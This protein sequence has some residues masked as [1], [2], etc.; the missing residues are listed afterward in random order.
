MK[1]SFTKTYCLG[2]MQVVSIQGRWGHAACSDA[3]DNKENEKKKCFILLQLGTLQRQTVCLDG[4]KTRVEQILT[5]PALQQ[6][7]CF[8]QMITTGTSIIMLK[9]LWKDNDCAQLLRLFS[10]I[11]FLLLLILDVLL[12]SNYYYTV[13]TEGN[14]TPK[15]VF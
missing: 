13:F 1:Q 4:K 15:P 5:Q 2:A 7:A 3:E 12:I 9:Q 14:Y 8:H 6:Q 11:Y 10:I